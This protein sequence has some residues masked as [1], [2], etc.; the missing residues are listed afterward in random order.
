MFLIVVMA[1]VAWAI[2]MVKIKE[3]TWIILGLIVLAS[4]MSVN[5]FISLHSDAAEGIMVCYLTEENCEGEDMKTCPLELRNDIYQF[6]L[7]DSSA[8]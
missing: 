1:L 7:H 5:F 6:E 8:K 2:L 4:Y 3:T